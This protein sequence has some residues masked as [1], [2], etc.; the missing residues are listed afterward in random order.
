MGQTSSISR[1]S[2]VSPG[3]AGIRRASASAASASAQS[4]S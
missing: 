3:L 4:T 2:I 1:I